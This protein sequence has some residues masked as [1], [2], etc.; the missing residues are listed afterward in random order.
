MA[1]QISAERAKHIV[2]KLG[3]KWGLLDKSMMDDIEGF[4]K[5]YRHTIDRRFLSLETVAAHSIKTYCLFMHDT[6]RLHS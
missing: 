1:G 5:E 6:N 3:E 2:Q 4:N